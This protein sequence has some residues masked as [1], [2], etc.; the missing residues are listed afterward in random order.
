VDQDDQVL[1]FAVVIGWY[2]YP[3]QGQAWKKSSAVLQLVHVLAVAVVPATPQK[4][5]FRC[6]VG[7]PT[8]SVVLK[9]GI[10]GESGVG[11]LAG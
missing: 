6:P 10:M 11:K 4:V 8:I 2:S 3:L 7:C 9:G 1:I 5:I